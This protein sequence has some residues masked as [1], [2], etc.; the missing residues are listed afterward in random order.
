MV[1]KKKN[2]S[3]TKN[4]NFLKFPQNTIINLRC[5]DLLKKKQL[6]ENRILKTMVKVN[7]YLLGQSIVMFLHSRFEGYPYSDVWR[8]G[9]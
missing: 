7:M 9:K 5:T 3:L 2:A 1:T 4:H 6:S 8:K